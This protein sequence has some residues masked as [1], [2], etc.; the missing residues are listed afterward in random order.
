MLVKDP[1]VVSDL[2]A[3]HKTA[4]LK[5]SARWRICLRQPVSGTLVGVISG[6]GNEI[7]FHKQVTVAAKGSEPITLDRA[8][9]AEL[10]LNDPKLWWPNGY[11]PQNLYT[12]TLDFRYG[13]GNVAE[14]DDEL[15]HSQD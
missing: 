5:I 4:D 10:H 11:G 13:E 6:Q 2:A 7:T 9:T 12:L 14:A 3:S 1:F 8:S 15:W